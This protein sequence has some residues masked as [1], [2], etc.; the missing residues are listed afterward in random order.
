MKPA[1]ILGTDAMTVSK[2]TAQKARISRG[3][4]LFGLAFALG[5][6]GP[7]GA[8]LL[9]MPPPAPSSPPATAP[10]PAAPAPT[11][12]A[13]APAPAAPPSLFG[14]PPPTSGFQQAPSQ[15][16]ASLFGSGPA[17]PAPAPAPA[18]T[19]MFG[20]P[21]AMAPQSPAEVPTM[22]ETQM[23]KFQERRQKQMADLDKLVKT[24]KTGKIDPVSSCP[25]L[26]SLVSVETEMRN[27]MTKEQNTCGIPGE[28]MSQMRDATGKTAQ[29]AERA[30]EAAAE[31]KRQQ[32]GGA[33]PAAP[34]MKLPAGPL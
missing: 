32:T 19:P 12:Q 3:L 29:I 27:W 7:A 14:A 33:A 31:M 34:A 10:A 20:G 9:T 22:C 28:I 4:A 11:A 13:P 30:C 24:S 8:Q 2:Q 21:A 6:T 16:P 15:A 17:A 23:T 18:A 26:R 25:K 5:T 1:I